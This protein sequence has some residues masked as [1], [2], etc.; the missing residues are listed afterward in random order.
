[1]GFVFQSFPLNGVPSFLL[2]MLRVDGVRSSR[3]LVSQFKFLPPHSSRHLFRSFAFIQSRLLPRL[4]TTLPTGSPA[5]SRLLFFLHDAPLFLIC[6]VSTWSQHSACVSLG[7]MTLPLRKR[8]L[9][10]ISPFS[11]YRSCGPPYLLPPV[12]RLVLS[13]RIHR[14]LFPFSVV[15]LHVSF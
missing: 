9:P 8:L 6:S 4:P 5:L 13:S 12:E 15:L 2:G 14:V 3:F 11:K 10:I 1:M 7:L